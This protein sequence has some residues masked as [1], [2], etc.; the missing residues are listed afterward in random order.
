[1]GFLKKIYK[2]YPKKKK[3]DFLMK[4]KLLLRGLY[5]FARTTVNDL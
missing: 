4:V 3:Q 2:E 5:C 1:M